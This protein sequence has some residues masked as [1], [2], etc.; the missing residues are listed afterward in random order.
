MLKPYV[1]EDWN[2]SF[3]SLF[4]KGPNMKWAEQRPCSSS[5]WRSRALQGCIQPDKKFMGL[6][7]V[8]AVASMTTH[9]QLSQYTDQDDYYYF[10]P[11]FC[12]K[13]KKF[14][15]LGRSKLASQHYNSCSIR[16]EYKDPSLQ[17]WH[18]RCPANVQNRNENWSSLGPC[19][20]QPSNT[21]TMT[22]IN[23]AALKDYWTSSY[24]GQ[25][26]ISA[27]FPSILHKRM[28]ECV[29]VG[30]GGGGRTEKRICNSAATAHGQE[31]VGKQFST[32]TQ[33]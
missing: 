16:T 26:S 31:K 33:E 2:C 25:C 4:V 1:K 23:T 20:V 21:C 10:V 13:R 6:Q 8:A 29:R 15:R 32:A 28:T 19:R 12:G 18:Q 9:W 5:S 11:A 17:C 24:L 14:S 3:S 7:T 30:G 27:R 22:H